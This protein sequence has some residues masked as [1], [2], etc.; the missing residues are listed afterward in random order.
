M[1]AFTLMEA[2]AELRVSVRRLTEIVKRH[3][4]YYP[5]GNRKLFTQD[6]LTSIRNALLEEKLTTEGGRTATLRAGPSP[7]AALKK[8]LTVLSQKRKRMRSKQTVE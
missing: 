8:A 4:Y 6:N 2:A 7:S 1:P 5:N 3:P